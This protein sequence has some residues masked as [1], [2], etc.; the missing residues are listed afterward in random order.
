LSRPTMTGLAVSLAVNDAW[1]L[2]I[3]DMFLLLL[4]RRARGR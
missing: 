4:A 1:T 3:S 2:M